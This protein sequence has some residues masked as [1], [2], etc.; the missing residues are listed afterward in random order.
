[1]RTKLLL[2]GFQAPSIF[3][4]THH[5]NPRT[6]KTLLQLW[7]QAARSSAPCGTIRIWLANYHNRF[8][9]NLCQQHDMTVSDGEFEAVL[10]DTPIAFFDDL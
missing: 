3:P 9:S 2:G 7:L 6:L 4:V 10:G 5:T 8:V 1:M